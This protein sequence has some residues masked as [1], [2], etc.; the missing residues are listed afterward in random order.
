MLADVGL[1]RVGLHGHFHRFG[2]DSVQVG[3]VD[4]I[5]CGDKDW[6][7]TARFT[8]QE[9]I[10]GP[11]ITLAVRAVDGFVDVAGSTVV[12]CNGEVPIVEHVVQ[13][14]EEQTSG[15]GGFDRIH[16]FID[17]RVDLQAVQASCGR[18]E[19]P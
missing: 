6:Q 3:V 2:T 8:W 11:E 16:A 18:H 13:R 5:C 9:R 10:N 1:N 12:G 14:F 7:I 17:Q 4:G 19:L 15:F